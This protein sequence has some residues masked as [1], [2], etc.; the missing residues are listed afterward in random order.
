MLSRARSSRRHS[1]VPQGRA[2]STNAQTTSAKV[3]AIPRPS[4]M[5]YVFHSTRLQSSSSSKDFLHYSLKR[6]VYIDIYILIKT[7]RVWLFLFFF[8]SFLED[9]RFSR[10]SEKIQTACLSEFEKN[11]ET[12][13]SRCYSQPW[14]YYSYASIALLKRM[15]SWMS[16]LIFNAAF[17]YL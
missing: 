9:I 13:V 6:S 11:P 8:F 7:T 16:R 3:R 10:R 12:P 2:Y 17:K 4:S 14:N 1:D 15:S 5:H